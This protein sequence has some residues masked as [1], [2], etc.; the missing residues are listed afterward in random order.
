MSDYYRV[1]T[2]SLEK[3]SQKLAN[4]FREIALIN[5]IVYIHNFNEF[6]TLN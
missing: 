3:L 2:K 5:T 6:L 1:K 4:L